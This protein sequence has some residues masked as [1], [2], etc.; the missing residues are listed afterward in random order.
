[1]AD[2]ADLTQE[3]Q[4]K[5]EDLLRR[6]DLGLPLVSATG[7]CLNCEAPLT[8]ERRWCDS[9]CRDGWERQ[10]KRRGKC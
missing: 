8:G 3:R 4:E 6:R 5:M 9:D 10:Q 7:V 2:D 1:M